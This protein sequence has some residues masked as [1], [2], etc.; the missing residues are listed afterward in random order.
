MPMIEGHCGLEET[1]WKILAPLSAPYV[2]CTISSPYGRNSA[3]CL[4]CGLFGGVFLKTL[5]QIRALPDAIGAH[6]CECEH[7]EMRRLPGGVY[8]CPACGSEVLPVSP[9]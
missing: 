5:R 1:A 7:P 9:P 2:K 6:A 8:S 3:R 4:R